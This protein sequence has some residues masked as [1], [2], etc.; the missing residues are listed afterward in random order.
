MMYYCSFGVCSQSGILHYDIEKFG[1]IVFI[2]NEESLSPMLASLT[3][4]RV[5]YNLVKVNNH[6]KCPCSESVQL[7]FN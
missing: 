1:I 4:R 6:S 2:I 3:F 7:Y 5:Q